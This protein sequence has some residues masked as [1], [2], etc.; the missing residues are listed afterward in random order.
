[1]L[2]LLQRRLPGGDLSVLASQSGLTRTVPGASTIV[3]LATLAIERGT[4]IIKVVEEAGSGEPISL[5]NHLADGWLTWPLAGVDPQRILVSGTGLTHLRSAIER[6]QM[7]ANTEDSRSDSMRMF[8]GGKA[9]GKPAPGSVGHQPEWFY[10]GNGS[11][12]VG[13]DQD[14]KRPAFAWDGGDEAEFAGLYLIGPGGTPY[15]LG[16]CLGN[17]FS[18]HLM[19]K[20]NYLWLA[21]SKLR[22]AAIGAEL[23]IGE[24]PASVRGRSR[25]LRAGQTIWEREFVSGEEHMTHSLA[26]LEHHHF[27]YRQFRRPGDLHVHF[28][29]AAALSFGDG[30]EAKNG[31]VFE[32]TAEPFAL[33]LRNRLVVTAEDP[34]RCAAL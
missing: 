34:V 30:V 7:H 4:T 12:I 24:F 21:H 32:I 28:F 5:V 26:N 25:I 14:L 18:D 8:L 9:G 6:D 2:K 15:R 29:G 20:Q 1:M 16:F 19:E 13:P 22:P 3:D 17:E 11:E 10:K 23:L 27:K 31:D 33:P